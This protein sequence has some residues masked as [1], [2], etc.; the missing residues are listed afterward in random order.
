MT[1]SVNVAQA[2]G[3]RH[4]NVVRDIRN[5][6]CSDSFRL[7]NFEETPYR[8]SQGKEYPSFRMTRDGFSILVMGFTGPKAMLWKERFLAMFNQMLE[9]VQDGGVDR[10]RMAEMAAMIEDIK[11][12]VDELA[13]AGMP[14]G[15]GVRRV[16][17]PEVAV[18]QTL[19]KVGPGHRCLKERFYAAYQDCCRAIG[20]LPSPMGVAMKALYA[21]FP[22][23]RPGR[24]K[25]NGERKPV[26]N[27]LSIRDGGKNDRS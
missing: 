16:Q 9:H 12:R 20:C 24:A 21:A 19:G 10:V 11:G 27:G 22:D 5:L 15:H 23:L 4:D 2:F 3:K 18:V 13:A 7:L 14:G 25:V 17:S 8:D 1:T 6:G 26:I